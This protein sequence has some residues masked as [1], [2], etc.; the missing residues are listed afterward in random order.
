[1]NIR[2]SYEKPEQFTRE[3]MKTMSASEITDAVKGGHFR[4]ILR[5]SFKS[6]CEEA[7]LTANELAR[8]NTELSE[9]EVK[10]A[11]LTKRAERAEAERDEWKRAAANA[12]QERNLSW[13]GEA[14][15]TAERDELQAKLNAT[16]G[17]PE[18]LGPRIDPDDYEITRNEEGDYL[19]DG[20]FVMDSS[21]TSDQA[22]LAARSLAARAVRRV[23][24]ARFIEAEQA[25]TGDEDRRV[26]EQAKV[27]C[28]ALRPVSVP[29]ECLSPY[30][31]NV[32]RAAIRAG[33]T[34]PESEAS[35]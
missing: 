19:A 32:Y 18:W 20:T 14:R 7:Q 17:W 28:G 30:F 4:D 34:P 16:E 15:L 21:V 35:E 22:R 26:E 2:P 24:L 5:P 10:I 3:D 23:A 12:L 13:K 6:C 29:W 1:M 27:L 9:A 33:W 11:A 31:K 8:R 25:A